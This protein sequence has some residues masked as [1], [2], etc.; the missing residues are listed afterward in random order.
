MAAGHTRTDQ[1]ETILYRLAS[2][3]S[4]RALYGMPAREGLLIRPLLSVTREETAAYCTE[5][6][7]SW[8]EDESN[9]SPA[10]AR[11]RVRGD[12]VPALRAVHPGAERNVLA[13]AEIL[14]DE[15]AALDALVDEVVGARHELELARLRALP[16]ALQRLVV[17]RMA[18]RAAGGLAPGAARRAAEVAGLGDRGTAQVEIGS[19]LRA[20]AEYGVLR[21]ERLG[22]AAA[23]P[24]PVA[25][26]IPGTAVFGAYEV[27]CELGPPEP[28]AGVLDRAELGR[29]LRVRGWRSGDRM[30][31]LGL[32]GTKSLQDLFTSR[33][34]PR[35]ERPS[36]PVVEAA[37]G[38]IAWVPGVATS[39]RFKVSEATTLAVRL[40]VERA[41]PRA[42]ASAPYK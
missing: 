1:V 25:L 38:E 33:R 29:E 42:R 9:D 17:Q 18:D 27:V 12:L 31:P 37:D 39:E 8:R 19:G 36:V 3:P 28:G 41:T 13:L 20:V 24:A 2:S 15:G 22:A 23:A 35:R 21:F 34:V 26:A 5:R 10:Y 32:N 4:R 30:A 14:R 6:G 7:L 40:R 16:T 11:G